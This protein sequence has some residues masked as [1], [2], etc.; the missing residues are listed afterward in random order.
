MMDG[1]PTSVFAQAAELD[2]VGLDVP[3]IT[4]L[5][6]RLRAKGWPGLP[7]V[8]LTA[9]QLKATLHVS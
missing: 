3:M 2:E 7:E 1:T 9:E 8:I 5:G 4:S 6:Q